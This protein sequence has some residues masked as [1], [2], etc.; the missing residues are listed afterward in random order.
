MFGT[1][2]FERFA[3]QFTQ[4]DTPA[5]VR[6]KLATEIRDKIEIVHTS[7]YGNFLNR[8]VPVFLQTLKTGKPQFVDCMEQK[9][10]NILLEIL[11]RL[12][13]QSPNQNEC[14]RPY[15]LELIRMAMHLLEVD[16]EPNAVIC[17]RIIFE[18]HKNYRPQ[19]QNEVQPFLDFV[20]KIYRDLKSNVDRMM[21]HAAQAQQAAGQAAIQQ[22]AGAVVA[23][24][25]GFGQSRP[26]QACNSSNSQG[27]LLS[28]LHSSSR[29]S[30]HSV[31]R[32]HLSP[33]P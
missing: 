30:Q 29:G 3:H 11:N 21:G 13:S 2:D 23:T 16:N 25:G 14:L 19:L 32:Q 7:E 27:R 18:L 12:P 22:Q 15:A 26:L 1:S 9:T 6:L 8:M 10:R 17:L 28:R 4:L 31:Q 20:Q 5:D 24:P 33:Q